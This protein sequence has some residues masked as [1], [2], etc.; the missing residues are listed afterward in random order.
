[1]DTD[2]L[3]HEALLKHSAG[4]NAGAKKLY[5][6]ILAAEPRHFNARLNLASMALDAGKLDEAASLLDALL[7]EDGSSGV[8]HLLRA[9]ASF[10]RGEHALGY[11]N[12]QLAHELMPEDDAVTGEYVAAMRRRAFTFNADEYKILREVAQMGQLKESRWQRLAQLTL[13]RMVTPEFIKLLTQ[14]AAPKDLPD[15][16]TRWQQDLPVERKNALSVMARDL[17]EYV[18]AMNQVE[19][20]KPQ[21]CNLQLR[22][23]QGAPE[24]EPTVCEAFTDVDSVTGATLELV[25]LHDVEFIPFADIR[26]VEFGELG[27]AVPTLVTL[28]GGKT[29]SGLVPLFYLFTDFAESAKVRTGK[30]TLFRAIVPGIVAGAGLRSFNSSRGLLPMANIERIDFK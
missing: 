7:T 13:A 24:Q 23:A 18:G 22:R 14:D 11:A 12:I 27:V 25:K 26:S 8:A 5:A 15:A 21:R 16:V 17:E 19:R 30:I 2:D 9:R 1:M 6:Q 4:D 28:A 10:L 29:T 20:F 3:L